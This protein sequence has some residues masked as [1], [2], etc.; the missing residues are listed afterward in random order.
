MPDNKGHGVIGKASIERDRIIKGFWKQGATQQQIADFLGV[1]PQAIHLRMKLMRLRREAPACDAHRCKFIS[2]LEIVN[3]RGCGTPLARRPGSNR[4]NFCKGCG[5]N[6]NRVSPE[7]FREALRLYAKGWGCR[8]IARVI[9]QGATVHEADVYA[10]ECV[11]FYYLKKW[12][13]KFRRKYKR[14]RTR[15]ISSAELPKAMYV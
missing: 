15:G 5:R 13:C 6:Y 8:T 2:R 3:C 14:K 1:T 10:V 12:G 11:L 9:R 4:R 7:G